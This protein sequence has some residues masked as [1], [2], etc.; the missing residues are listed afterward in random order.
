M[1]AMP[2]R[3][4]GSA[5]GAA[6][7]AELPHRKMRSIAHSPA[8]V[9]ASQ[10]KTPAKSQRARAPVAEAGPTAMPGS[11]ADHRTH[12]GVDAQGTT[13]EGYLDVG[14]PSAAGTSLRPAKHASHPGHGPRRRQPCWRRGG[15]S[16]RRG[17]R[18]RRRRGVAENHR[19]TISVRRPARS[20]GSATRRQRRIPRCLPTCHMSRASLLSRSGKRMS[21]RKEGSF[22]SQRRFSNATSMP[23][24]ASRPDG[25]QRRCRIMMSGS[26]RHRRPKTTASARP[27]ESSVSCARPTSSRSLRSIESPTSRS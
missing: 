5:R 4:S 1:V 25:A 13:P 10:M 12:P 21:L 3:G 16:E 27:S 23:D 15:R 9:S 24:P 7:C 19:S 22:R 20:P 11:I 14:V 18:N 26:H 8:I 6:Q 17:A 2:E